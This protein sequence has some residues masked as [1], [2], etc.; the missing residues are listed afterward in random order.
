V[1]DRLGYSKPLFFI[2]EHGY[3]SLAWHGPATDRPALSREEASYLNDAS[4]SREV[5][6]TFAYLEPKTES[7]AQ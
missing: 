2:L 4:A 3:L 1:K 5:L 6:W 7:G